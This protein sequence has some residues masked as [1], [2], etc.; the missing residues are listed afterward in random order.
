[1]KKKFMSNIRCKLGKYSLCWEALITSLKITAFEENK[2]HVLNYIQS[3]ILKKYI[4]GLRV[5]VGGK[6]RGRKGKGRVGG[7][8]DRASFADIIGNFSINDGNGKDNS[9]N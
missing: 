4:N 2:R 7:G 8:T 6:G 5:G 3:K 9:T 1:M